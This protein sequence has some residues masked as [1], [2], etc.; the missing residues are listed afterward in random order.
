MRLRQRG[1]RAGVRT[2]PKCTASSGSPGKGVATPSQPAASAVLRSCASF[3]ALAE[4]RGWDEPEL[5]AAIVSEIER[6]RRR[7]GSED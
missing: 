1:D 7:A 5:D 2:A 3:R 6:A 4:E